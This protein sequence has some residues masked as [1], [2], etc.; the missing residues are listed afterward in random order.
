MSNQQERL[1]QLKN[2]YFFFLK[3]KKKNE[4]L[5]QSTFVQK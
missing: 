2:I 3:Q 5:Y 4:N 1:F